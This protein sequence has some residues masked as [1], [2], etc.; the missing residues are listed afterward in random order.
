VAH[1]EYEKSEKRQLLEAVKIYKNLVRK[2]LK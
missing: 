1:T 2:L